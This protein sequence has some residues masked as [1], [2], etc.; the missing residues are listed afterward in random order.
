M[1]CVN[2]E[3]GN[4]IEADLPEVSEDFLALDFSFIFTSVFT[5]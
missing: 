2:R 1:L 5:L 4:T 3:M